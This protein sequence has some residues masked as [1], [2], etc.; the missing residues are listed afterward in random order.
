MESD[1][2]VP[3]E[4]VEALKAVLDGASDPARVLR[5]LLD[6]AVRRSGAERGIFVQVG[7]GGTMDYTVL[8]RYSPGE[9]AGTAGEFSRSLFAEVLR[10]GKSIVLENALRSHGGGAASSVRAMR[11]VSV[12]CVPVRA[13]GRIAGIV[14]LE[15]G[16]PGRFREAERRLV[17]S[18]VGVGGPLIETLLAGRRTL[19]ERDRLR[20]AR[21]K[22]EVEVAESRGVLARDWSFGRFVGRSPSVRALEEHVR[23]AA[24]ASWPVLIL[25]ETGTGKGIVAR[26]LHY[27]SPRASKPFV[28]VFCPNLE[29]GL[30]ES[31]LFGHRRGAF[32]GADHDR[33]GKVQ[34]AEGGTLFLDEV[35]ELPLELQPR[36]LRLLQEKTYERLGDP[37]ERV[38]DVR[39]VAATN[40]DLPEEVAAGRF[41]RDL[42]ERLN[43]LTVTIPPLRER[44]SDI[45]LLLR[46]ALDRT[47]SGRWIEIGRDAERWI[48]GLDHVWPGNVRQIEQ[49]A[50]RLSLQAFGAPASADDLARVLDAGP[51][52]AERRAAG[53]DRD[54]G[55]PASL[56]RYERE[57]LARALERHA[58][59]T[60]RELAERLRISEPTLYKKLKQYGL[61]GRN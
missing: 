7:A 36:L 37:E 57:W 45:P 35:G 6:E 17:E 8:H 39:V 24:A 28:T 40:R 25:G 32:T 60:R 9:V 27:A 42:Y 2:P 13:E 30:V 41:R 43:Y 58:G 54:D 14:H 5:A 56:E 53:E 16:T 11:L 19:E 50:A 26:V 22:V 52:V 55:L 15:H 4:L 3:L 12:L 33:A 49:L 20:E 1:N 31:E 38:A 61:G 23:K 51:A 29:R 48:A 34:A 44:R 18:L 59:C 47:G 10:T 46:D 21:E